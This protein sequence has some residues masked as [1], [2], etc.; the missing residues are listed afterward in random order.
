MNRLPE[1]TLLDVW[2]QGEGQ[3]TIDRALLLL[4]S[5]YTDIGWEQLASLSLGRRDELLLRL[6]SNLLGPNIKANTICPQCGE[7]TELDVDIPQIL[8]LVNSDNKQSTISINDGRFH[9]QGRIPNSFDLAAA[10]HRSDESRARKELLKHCIVCVES[11]AQPVDLSDVPEEIISK[12]ANVIEK[13][14]PLAEIS[15]ELTCPSCGY[16]WDELLDMSSFLWEEIDQLAR[17][18]LREIHLLAQAYGWSEQDVLGM[19]RQRRQAYM[20]RAY[21]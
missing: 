6:R 10:A 2:E 14:D 8:A 4:S 12:L 20:E 18:I 7:R 9:L 21:E 19:S 5:A 13:A 15:I 11:D 16:H 3:H 1:H 17:R